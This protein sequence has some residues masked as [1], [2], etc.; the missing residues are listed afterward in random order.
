MPSI[1]ETDTYHAIP[2]P[3]KEQLPNEA[4]EEHWNQRAK[5]KG[6]QT[7][8]SS[9][10][11]LTENEAATTALQKH[12]LSFLDKILADQDVFELGVGIGRMTAE[13]AKVTKSVTGCDLTPEML[14]KARAHLI[15]T[16]NVTLYQGRITDMELSAESF[17]LVFESIVLL[18]ILNP[19]ELRITMTKMRE[20]SSSYVFICEHTKS[21]E[22]NPQVSK[23][24]ILRTPQDYIELMR[25]FKLV[26]QESHSCAGDPFTLMLFKRP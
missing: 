13:I 14:E 20:L 23:Y 12:I 24:T 6:V 19:E 15:H 4:I 2:Q 18:H 1:K 26:K 25:P 10:H 21:Q 8:M 3:E 17:P 5:R 9:R 16:H 11:T 7:V 22:E